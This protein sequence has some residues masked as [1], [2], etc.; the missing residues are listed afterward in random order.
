MKVKN[1]FKSGGSSISIIFLFLSLL[2]LVVTASIFFINSM[3]DIFPKSLPS[4]ELIN[5]NLIYE[6]MINNRN[7]LFI[8]ASIFFLTIYLVPRLTGRVFIGMKP[9][10]LLAVLVFGI[11]IISPY[12]SYESKNNYGIPYNLSLA[13]LLLLTLFVLIASINFIKKAEESLFISGYFLL[14][15][16]IS[17]VASAYAAQINLQTTAD[18]IIINSFF[19]SLHFYMGCGFASLCIIFFLA[20]KGIGGTLENNSLAYITLW[21]YLFLLPWVSF[22]FY[23]GSF[24]PNWLENISIYMSLGLIVPLIAFLSNIIKTLQSSEEDRGTIYRYLNYSVYFFTFGNILLIL[25]GVPSL[26]S[27][28]SFTFWDEAIVWSF[29]LSLASGMLGVCFYTIPK[30]MGREYRDEKISQY[31]YLIGST[32]LVISLASKGIV[33]GYMWTA[34]AN[35]GTFTTFGEGYALT[36]QAISQFNYLSTL[37]IAILIIS[38]LTFLFNTFRAITSGEVVAQEVLTGVVGNNE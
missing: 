9:A 25:G 30:L 29:L 38:I 2:S 19:T 5:S 8:Y 20:T 34:G 7:F 1:L 31:L 3:F 21:G 17:L 28:V 23:F 32:L 33:S 35:A 22:K 16:L 15:S 13:L 18:L 36:W 11:I 4:G 6:L 27:L 26:I 24:L 10:T 12:L 37:G 14:A